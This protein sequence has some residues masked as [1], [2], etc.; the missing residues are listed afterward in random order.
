MYVDMDIES[1]IFSETRSD[2]SEAI[3]TTIYKMMKNESKNGKVQL[4]LDITLSDIKNAYT[5]V[6]DTVPRISYKVT[7]QITEKED[8]AG[9]VNTSEIRVEY[10]SETGDFSFEKGLGGQTSMNI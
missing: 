8:T 3:R 6:V 5:G 9:I 4:T 7:K 2:V 1:N 10:D